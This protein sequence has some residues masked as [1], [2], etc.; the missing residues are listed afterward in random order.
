MKMEGRRMKR[1]QLR[2]LPEKI[3]YQGGEENWQDV[4]L[5]KPG[6]KSTP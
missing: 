3:P 5:L 2:T 1:F 6:V 4:E